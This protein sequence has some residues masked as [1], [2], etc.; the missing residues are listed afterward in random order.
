MSHGWAPPSCS[1]YLQSSSSES[2]SLPADPRP[3]AVRVRANSNGARMLR[4]QDFVDS[5]LPGT[6]YHVM[7]LPSGIL[8]LM[9]MPYH[10]INISPL[11]C[12]KCNPVPH[13]SAEAVAEPCR[14]WHPDQSSLLEITEAVYHR[15][16]CSQCS[17]K[18]KERDFKNRACLRFF[19][20]CSL[21]F[22]CIN[23]LGSAE[24]ARLGSQNT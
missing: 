6:A 12:L 18:S 10:G 19:L 16:P 15:A 3:A 22:I 7:F 1:P 11:I 20:C 2:V 13:S 9:D 5:C 8:W 14:D 4:S 21:L 23:P 24:P 17:M